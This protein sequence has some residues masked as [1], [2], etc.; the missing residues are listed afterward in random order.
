MP[1]IFSSLMVLFAIFHAGGICVG[2]KSREEI[3]FKRFLPQCLARS[4][5]LLLN[6]RSLSHR[7]E[8]AFIWPRL[9]IYTFGSMAVLSGLFP[10]SLC[11]KPA[12]EVCGLVVLAC[13]SSGCGWLLEAGSQVLSL[14]RQPWRLHP[15][16]SHFT[17][18]C[19]FIKSCS[20]FRKCPFPGPLLPE[21]K[22]PFSN[23]S[24]APPLSHGD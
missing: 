13:I 18:V 3:L 1:T 7:F 8:T 20:T 11:L 15:V 6:N 2:T 22:T 21:K 5:W 19:S 10:C 23:C 12:S 16:S 24:E 4:P 14:C 9:P 17:P